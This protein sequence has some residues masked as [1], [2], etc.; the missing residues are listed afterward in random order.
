MNTV[1]MASSVPPLT[2]LRVVT[3]WRFAP[4]VLGASA[5]LAGGYAAGLRRWRGRWPRSRTWCFGLGIV[6]LLLVGCSFLGVYDD[7]LFWVRAVQNIV[8]LMVVP[9]LLAMG[10]PLTLLAAA[11]PSPLRVRLSRILHSR[12]LVWATVP[13]VVTVLLIVPILVLYMSPLYEATL[14]DATVSGAV[15]AM[16]MLVGFVYFWTRFRV[17]PTP[18]AGSYGVTLAITI[19][20]MVGDAVLGVVVWLGP[21]IAAGFYVAL[22]RQWGPDLRT[23]QV[24]GAGVLWVGGDVVG[25]PFIAIVFSRMAR[26]DEQRARDI[27]AEL[28]ARALARGTEQDAEGTAAT[29]R[30]AGSGEAGGVAE[31]GPPARLWWEDDPQIADRFRRRGSGRT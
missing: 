27:D 13:P 15:A 7:T 1:A 12:P 2:A 9:M 3:A 26:E 25:L 23:D 28:D 24:I 19:V 14:R 11:V 16:L 6:A 8:L 29:H 30:A 4:G 17:D 21:L 5:V 18:R 20:E 31:G 22:N 10:A